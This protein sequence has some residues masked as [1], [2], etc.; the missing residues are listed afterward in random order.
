MAKSKKDILVE[1]S[2]QALISAIEIYNK[3]DFKYREENFAILLV[4]AWELLL[5]AKIISENNNNS[6]SIYIKEPIKNDIGKNTKKWKYKRTR[7]KNVMTIDISR[8]LNLINTLDQNVK[9]NIE[10]LVEIRDNAVHF[11]NCS[12]DF[13]KNIHEVGSASIYDY[14]YILKDWFNLTLNKYNLYLLPLS[15]IGGRDIESIPLVNNEKKLLEY[16]ETMKQRHPYNENETTHYAFQVQITLTKKS[17]G[18]SGLFL[19]NDPNAPKVQLSEDQLAAKYPLT[20]EQLCLN[21]E[22][23]Y[24]N[25]RRDKTF[26]NTKKKFEGDPKFCYKRFA[27]LNQTGK[28]IRKFYSSTLLE[29]LDKVYTKR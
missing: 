9:D 6:K 14:I 22:K 4:N 18:S 12:I 5:K 7:S 3:P 10:T 21:C 24:T 16:I 25:F 13:V 26:H 11:Y 2:L 15:F 17:K 23:R 1:K 8:C 20:F 19:T 29:E 28:P 27:T